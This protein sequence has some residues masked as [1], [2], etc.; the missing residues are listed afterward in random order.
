PA[1]P[2]HSYGN[3]DS[4]TDS[5]VAAGVVLIGDAAGHND[6]IIGQGLSITLR[7]VRIVSDLLLA[8]GDW[9]P[10][11]FAPYTEE[12]RER[13]R[14]LRFAAALH[15]RLENEF[16]PEAEARRLRA[17]ELQLKDPSL[18]LWFVAA[19]VGPDALPAAAFDDSVR[20]RLLGA[21]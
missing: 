3:E 16:G 2:C 14:R 5:P 11:A 10:A 21:A 8:G 7:D 6:P 18:A 15:S 9:S 12:R 4:W 19:F 1:G 13:M 20:E 17:S